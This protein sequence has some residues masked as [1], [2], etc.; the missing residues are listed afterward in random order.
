MF[1]NSRTASVNGRKIRVEA[2]SIGVISTYIGFG[3]P[4]GKAISLKYGP[5]PWDRMPTQLKRT[6]EIAARNAGIA[7]L[8]VG[9]ICPNGMMPMRLLARMKKNRTA[10]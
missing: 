8:D 4:G 10:R 6:Y 7:I 1:A 9:A 3:T 2:S 5:M